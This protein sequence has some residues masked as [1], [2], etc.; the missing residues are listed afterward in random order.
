MR[1]A[2]SDKQ[3]VNELAREHVQGEPRLASLRRGYHA[4]RD[5]VANGPTLLA[6]AT[7]EF[8]V[9]YR[10]HMRKE[11]R[12]LL[13]LAVARLTNEEWQRVESAF[14]DNTDPLFG[15][16][17]A[18]DYRLLYECIIELAPDTLKSYLDGTST[19]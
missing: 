19:V 4:V 16:D 9:F 14:G 6:T 18:D 11:E 7:D 12:Q 1:F 2:A 13:P 10:N 5:G 8:T 17:L 3:L 15:A